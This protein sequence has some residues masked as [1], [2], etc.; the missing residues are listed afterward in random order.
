MTTSNPSTATLVRVG[1]N[2]TVLTTS[3]AT[4]NSKPSNKVLPN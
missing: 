2:A 1:S 3:A 4:R